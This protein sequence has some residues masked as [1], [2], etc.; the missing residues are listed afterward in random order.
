[1]SKE[2]WIGKA[3]ERFFRQTGNVNLMSPADFL[4]LLFDCLAFAF[5]GFEEKPEPKIINPEP[6]YWKEIDRIVKDLDE[7]RK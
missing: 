3:K 2:D 4:D 7:W 1:M 5:K 6:E